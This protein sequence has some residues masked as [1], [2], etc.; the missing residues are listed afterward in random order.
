V[1]FRE[2]SVERKRNERILEAEKI[3]G[4]FGYGSTYS[5]EEGKSVCSCHLCKEPYGPSPPPVVSIRG[6]YDPDNDDDDEDSPD[7]DDEDDEDEF[8]HEDEAHDPWGY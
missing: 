4:E 5:G 7:T 8:E 3:F 6:G 2:R 1:E